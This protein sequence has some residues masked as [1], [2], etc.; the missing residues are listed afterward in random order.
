MI[1]GPRANSGGGA[2]FDQNDIIVGRNCLVIVA[3]SIGCVV[4]KR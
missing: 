3:R 4:V 2:A 1:I